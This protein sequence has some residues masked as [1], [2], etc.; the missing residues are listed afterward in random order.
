MTSRQDTSIGG[1]ITM[2]TTVNLKKG[3]TVGV[4]LNEGQLQEGAIFV[5]LI[6]YLR[7]PLWKRVKYGSIM[8]ENA[9]SLDRISVLPGYFETSNFWKSPYRL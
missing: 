1:S 6:D 9:G 7:E 4:I 3:D 5:G 8:P 2:K